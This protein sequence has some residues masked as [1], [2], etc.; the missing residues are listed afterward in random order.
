MDPLAGGARGG[1]ASLEGGRTGGG[2]EEE[3]VAWPGR[4][5]IRSNRVPTTWER[6]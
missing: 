6:R 4:R 3:E 1:A 2:T 5:P